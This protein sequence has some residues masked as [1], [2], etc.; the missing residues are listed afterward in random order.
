MMMFHLIDDDKK[1][2]AIVVRVH[3]AGLDDISNREREIF[4]QQVSTS[5][6]YLPQYWYGKTSS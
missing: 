5:F 4:F 1:E 3:G 6:Y 2:D